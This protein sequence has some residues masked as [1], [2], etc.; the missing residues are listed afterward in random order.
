M[1]DSARVTNRF[2]IVRTLRPSGSP[3]TRGSFR[4]FKT[5][6]T[7]SWPTNARVV[8]APAQIQS[9]SQRISP[10]TSFPGLFNRRSVSAPGH[11]DY[12][13][14]F[15]DIQAHVFSYR[16]HMLVS[17]FGC[18]FRHH[19]HAAR[20]PLRAQSAFAGTSPICFCGCVS[21]AAIM[22]RQK[23]ENLPEKS[24]DSGTGSPSDERKRNNFT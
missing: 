3:P 17:V 23:Y 21:R 18:W 13:H 10:R 6:R 1:A 22:S 8:D 2:V 4:N 5:D 12:R 14:I 24:V 20:L 15:V 9:A 7:D 19:T 16:P 11:R